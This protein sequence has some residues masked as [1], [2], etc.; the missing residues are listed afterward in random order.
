[1]YMVINQ[2]IASQ[3]LKPKLTQRL[4]QH[5]NIIISMGI[6]CVLKEGIERIK[7]LTLIGN[8]LRPVV[9]SSFP[10]HLV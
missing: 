6:N 4:S 10:T 8:R 3:H 7:V 1:M 2:D 9:H 5:R